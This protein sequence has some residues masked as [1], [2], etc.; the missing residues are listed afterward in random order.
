MR[1][2][3]IW[4]KRESDISPLSHQPMTG[5]RS[6]SLKW[7]EVSIIYFIWEEIRVV[8]TPLCALSLS[9]LGP[10]SLFSHPLRIQLSV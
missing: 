4:P 1:A 5:S 6:N 10:W 8:G 7:E 2:L 9:H 3:F